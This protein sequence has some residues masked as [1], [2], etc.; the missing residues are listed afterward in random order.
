MIVSKAARPM[1]GSATSMNGEAGDSLSP[2]Q[3]RHPVGFSTVIGDD[4]DA[5]EIL[6]VG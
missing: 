3:A 1:T 2:D 4:L 6:P 5:N